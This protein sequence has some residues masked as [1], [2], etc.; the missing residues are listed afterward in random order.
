MEK[1]PGTGTLP[2]GFTVDGVVH[3]DFELRRPNLGDNI[4]A[5]DEVGG[6]E[7][8]LALSAAIMA[9]QLV[10]LGSLPKEK[11]TTELLRSADLDD[12]NALDLAATELTK[13]SV[14]PKSG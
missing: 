10:K 14:P 12:W 13:K 3:K 2:I 8:A 4:D 6:N 11:I 1:K 9:R 5:I 7:N